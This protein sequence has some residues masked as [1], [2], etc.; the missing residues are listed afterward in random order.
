VASGASTHAGKSKRASGLTLRDPVIHVFLATSQ[1]RGCQR[2]SA[3]AELRN[4]GLASRVNPTCAD[5]PGHD[6]CICG[7]A[8]QK[9][10]AAVSG[11]LRYRGDPHWL[12]R[13]LPAPPSDA[14]FRSRGN[15]GTAAS[16][17]YRDKDTDPSHFHDAIRLDRVFPAR[18]RRMKGG[19]GVWG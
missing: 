5:K 14:F 6:E 13:L 8:G 15:S 10:K 4:L 16:R 19:C 17:A 9:Q 2:N 3:L 7:G 12:G 1:R 18:Q 11:G